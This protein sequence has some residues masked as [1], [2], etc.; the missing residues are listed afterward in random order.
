VSGPQ[1]ELS[2]APSR[3]AAVLPGHRHDRNNFNLLRLVF[4]TL[5][6]V[7]HSVPLTRGSNQTELLWVWSGGG[8]TLGG[9]AVNA[10]FLL[11]GYLVTQSWHRSSSA[12]SYVRKRILRIYPGYLAAFGCS[13]I[14]K[15]VAESW[16]L[17]DGVGWFWRNSG[18]ILR[19]V[20]FFNQRTL[21]G[22]M[23]FA[24]NPFPREVNGS[25]W[26][27]QPEVACYLVLMALGALG[28]LAAPKV[29]RAALVVCYVAFAIEL[30]QSPELGAE[31]DSSWRFFT[32]FL[33]GSV[34]AGLPASVFAIRG[35]AVA[36]ALSA[37][38]AGLF[39]P[40]WFALSVPLAGSYLI[41]A[42]GGSRHTVGAGLFSRLDISYGMY[43]YAFPVAQ[44][45]VLFLG[46]R[47]P[48]NL[49]AAALPITAVMALLSWFLVE[50]PMLRSAS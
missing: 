17:G 37:I 4:A 12:G 27:L 36:V 9:L 6:L 8:N 24:N 42:V 38:V 35:W 44:L 3:P 34:A 18:A 50:R 1:A 41:L 19:D 31:R 14:V 10:F 48:L 15:G 43:L 32:Y 5:V 28:L 7:S 46:I 26:T 29:I 16:S 11:S 33:A 22:P 45:C 25:L 30:F 13:V 39:L 47:S 20:L 23:A 49:I 21:H 40:P 2:S